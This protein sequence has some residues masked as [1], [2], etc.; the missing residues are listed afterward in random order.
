MEKYETMGRRFAALLIDA[1]VLGAAYVIFLIGIRLLGTANDLLLLVLFATINLA[2]VFYFI[3]LHAFYGQTIGKRIADI[4]VV[5]VSEA[6]TNFGQS[7]L[8]S[9]PLLIPA[10]FTV[11]LISRETPPD[12][13]TQIIGTLIIVAVSSFFVIDLGVFVI[14]EKR[15]ALHDFIAQTVVVRTDV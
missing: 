6:P 4:K 15:R 7:V 12:L 1:V 8:R 14:N 2:G 11:T 10:L 5:S 13:A 3:L 9:M